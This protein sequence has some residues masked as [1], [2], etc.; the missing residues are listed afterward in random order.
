MVTVQRTPGHSSASITLDVYGH[1]WP[2]S[3]DRTRK[4]AAQL[5]DDALTPTADALRTEGKY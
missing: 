5:F 2:D 3:N 4:A 1:L